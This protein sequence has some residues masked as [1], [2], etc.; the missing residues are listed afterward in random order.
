MARP[1]TKKDKQGVLYT[2]PAAVDRIIDALTGQDLGAI[3][4][5][6]EISNQDSSQYL[7]SECLVYAIRDAGR[8]GDE[9]A[10]KAVLPFLLHRCEAILR[11]KIR[12]EEFSDAE[13]M[14]DDVLGEFALL[15]AADLTDHRYHLDFFECRFN[16]AFRTFYLRFIRRERARCEDL[17]EIPA[18]DDPED[19]RT[20]EEVL[21]A[22]SGEILRPWFGGRGR[23][24]EEM[25]DAITRLST[26][27]QKAVM[28][29]FYYG[30]PEESLD[31]AKPSVASLCGVTGKTVRNR[32]GRAMKKLAEYLR[33]EREKL[34]EPKGISET[35]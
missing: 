34:D 14:I 31:P 20:D 35:A 28:L 11:T 3:V 1:L 16:A 25:I 17:V 15:F 26:N 6:A 12:R 27:E 19:D 23:F 7:P 33:L 8:R 22:M 29:R 21:T 30:L 24:S 4:H 10:M 18:R 9:T 5:R 13:E 2:R 32:L